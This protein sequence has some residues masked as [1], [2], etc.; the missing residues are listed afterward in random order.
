MLDAQN[1]GPECTAYGSPMKL[2]A[3]EPSMWAKACERF[4]AHDAR[5]FIGTSSIAL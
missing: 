5:E 3:I 4:L 1:Q 2:A